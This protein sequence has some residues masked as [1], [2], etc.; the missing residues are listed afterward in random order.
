V[1]IKKTEV[2]PSELG[3]FIQAVLKK[4]KVPG[5]MSKLLKRMVNSLE[6]KPN[7]CGVGIDI[8]KLVE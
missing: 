3:T 7:I 8:K 2:L 5:S 6:L 4:G 1:H